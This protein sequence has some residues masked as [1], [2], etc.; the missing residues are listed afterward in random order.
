MHIARMSEGR[1]VRRVHNATLVGRRNRGRSVK[2]GETHWC[3]Q[4]PGLQEEKKKK[5]KKKKEEEE[6]EEKKKKKEEEEEKKKKK[7]LSY[8]P[9]GVR[10][11]TRISKG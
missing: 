3:K 1:L 5:K 9:S 11:K 2:D 10:N 6:E 7:I 4:V 8:K